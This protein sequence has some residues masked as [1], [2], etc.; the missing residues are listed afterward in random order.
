MIAG[1]LATALTARPLIF[2][3]LGPTAIMLFSTPLDRNA[4]PR[5]VLIGHFIG[6][7]SGYFG[8][9]VTGLLAVPLSAHVGTNRVIAAAIALAL[10]AGLMLVA[11][12]E[13]PPA[14]ATT[15]IVALGILPQLIDFVFLMA[16]VV[17][18][19]LLGLLVNR[20]S[21]IPYPLWSD[22]R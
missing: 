17:A 21:G 8:L 7:A 15:L 20:A 18:L 10:T 3:S 14:G 11:K 13:H 9:A 19:T 12:A 5:H 1:G 16:A 4:S 2:P 6:A 22:R